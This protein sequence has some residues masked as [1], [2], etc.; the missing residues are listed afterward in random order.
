MNVNQCMKTHAVSIVATATVQEAVRLFV[1]HHIGTLPVVDETNQLV[2][3]LHLRDI[4]KLVMPAFVDLIP[5]FDFVEAD[6][7]IFEDLSIPPDT[8]AA[9]IQ[10]I[11]GPPVSVRASSGLL[12]AFAIL[13]SHEMYDLPVVDSDGRLVGLASR[14][15]VG[16]ALLGRWQVN[17]HTDTSP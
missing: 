1:Q 11:M 3:I 9:P 2:G 6:F 8:A 5:D 15:D 4:L 13:D 17:S 7:G 16:T 14:V 12:R 10:T